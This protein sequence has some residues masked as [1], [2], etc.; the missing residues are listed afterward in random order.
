MTKLLESDGTEQTGILEV[1][2]SLT[3]PTLL[4]WRKSV[5]TRK[6]ISGKVWAMEVLFSKHFKNKITYT[7][8][9]TY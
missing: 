5:L 9:Y 4:F 2:G 3:P 7:C 6:L 1:W 8:M